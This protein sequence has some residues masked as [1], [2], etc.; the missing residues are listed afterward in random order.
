MTVLFIKNLAQM[1]WIS[2]LTNHFLPSPDKLDKYLNKSFPADKTQKMIYKV[3]GKKYPWDDYIGRLHFKDFVMSAS[4][5]SGAI[6]AGKYSGWDDSRL[7]T[8]A[9]LKKQG[10][11]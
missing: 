3:L 10:Y 7:P 8:A 9:S 11:S 4:K 6:I 2:T 5:I 1:N